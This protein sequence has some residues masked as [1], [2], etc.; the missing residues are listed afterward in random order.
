MTDAENMTLFER[1]DAAGRIYM[2]GSELHGDDKTR[3]LVATTVPEQMPLQCGRACRWN[4][5]DSS[6]HAH[7]NWS[8]YLRFAVCHENAF[9]AIVDAPCG[10]LCLCRLQRRRP[11]PALPACK[12]LLQNFNLPRTC[13]KSCST[14]SNHELLLNRA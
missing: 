9:G 7:R 8:F 11:T 1:V 13:A 6:G 3:E 4:T 12:P 14:R 5:S 2:I 10:R